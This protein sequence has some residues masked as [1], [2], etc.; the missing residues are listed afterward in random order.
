MQTNRNDKK[1][2]KGFA[3]ILNAFFY[4]KDG[5]CAAWSDEAAFRQVFVLAIVCIILA[6]FVADSWLERVVLVAPCVISVLIELLNS[7]IENAIDFVSLKTHPLAKKAKDMG[8]AAQLFALIFWVG[9]WV[10]FFWKQYF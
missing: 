4:S 3:R 9:I 1:G 8:S 2:K 6:F 10:S 7:A 5:F